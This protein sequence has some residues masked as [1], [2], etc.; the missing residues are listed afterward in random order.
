MSESHGWKPHNTAPRD[1]EI[2]VMLNGVVR[3]V[4]WTDAFV[5]DYQPPVSAGW[6]AL[7]ADGKSYDPIPSTGWHWRNPGLHS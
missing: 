2:E 3:R 1:R 4:H 6:Y 7:S 5:D